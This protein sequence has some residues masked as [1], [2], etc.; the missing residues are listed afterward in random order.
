MAA[1]QINMVLNGGQGD[2]TTI[3][4]VAAIVAPGA[5]AIAVFLEN[6]VDFTRRMEII[7]AWRKVWDGIR[8]QGQIANF[9][10]A[11]FFASIPLDK[12]TDPNR[13]FTAAILE[14]VDGEVGLSIDAALMDSSEGAQQMLESA[15][16]QLRD[17]AKEIPRWV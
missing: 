2:K 14:V 12:T 13:R 1:F 17:A 6:T 11:D 16:T 3:T 4:T 10:A 9:A 8:D 7:N 5:N 15:F